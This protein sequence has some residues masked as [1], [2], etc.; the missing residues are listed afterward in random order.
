MPAAGRWQLH[1]PHYFS[2]AGC[3]TTQ[4]GKALWAPAQG[5]RSRGERSSSGAVGSRAA[6]QGQRGVASTVSLRADTQKS[7]PRPLGRCP[8]R[9][10]SQWGRH[11]PFFQ[12]HPC[13]GASEQ[14]SSVQWWGGGQPCAAAGLGAS[15]GAQ[16]LQPPLTSPHPPC[17][18][19]CRSQRPSCESYH[20]ARR[21]LTPHI[22]W[23]LCVPAAPPPLADW[24]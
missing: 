14:L 3:V 17:C 10:W 9:G 21:A 13:G 20:S 7:V 1:C 18:H 12:Q 24:G 15:A 22:S 8:K 6:A 2:L 19:L 11:L 5:R 4:Q 23:P 16:P